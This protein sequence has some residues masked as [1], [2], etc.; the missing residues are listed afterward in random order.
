MKKVLVISS[1]LR[2][3][4]NS[5][6]LADELLKGAKDAGHSVEKVTLQNKTIG[7]CNGCLAC[8]QTQH[9]VIS[10]D[11][12]EIAEKMKASDVL[13]FA[14]PVYYYGMSGQL[15]TL[16]DRAN[17]LFPSDYQFR[18]IYLVAAAAE[19][20]DTAFEGTVTGITGW[21]SCFEK[22][23]LSGVICGK[24]LTDSG[25][26]VNAAELLSKAYDMG[27]AL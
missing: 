7:F 16:L 4:S 18:E 9:C 12:V 2:N 27:K 10:D 25:E 26:A 24:G 21:V 14:T 11:A 20:E 6:C 17:P 23:K 13:V 5:E 3:G 15:K 22:A 19:D 1:S 8:Q